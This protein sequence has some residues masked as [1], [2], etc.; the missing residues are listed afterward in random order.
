MTEQRL[1]ARVAQQHIDDQV[2]RDL[3]VQRARALAD[4]VATFH[5]VADSQEEMDSIRRALGRRL[6]LTIDRL[7]LAG[8]ADAEAGLADA[9]E[10]RAIDPR[11][12]HPIAT[13]PFP[14]PERALLCRADYPPGALTRNPPGFWTPEAHP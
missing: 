10:W 11:H 13:W 2:L 3:M 1:A 8:T 5:G 7:L 12:R 4:R 6:G 14:Y 9:R